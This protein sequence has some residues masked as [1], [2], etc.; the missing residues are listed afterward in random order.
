MTFEHIS[1]PVESRDVEPSTRG[2]GD[3]A[4]RAIAESRAGQRTST[5]RADH[6]LE[7]TLGARRSGRGAEEAT[8]VGQEVETS[9]LRRRH[10]PPQNFSVVRA[11]D[12]EEAGGLEARLAQLSGPDITPGQ[13]TI[14]GAAARS[15]YGHNAHRVPD[16][17]LQSLLERAPLFERYGV[18]TEA[19]FKKFLKP[20]IA[21]NFAP[22]IGRS[23][24]LVV[25]S[26]VGTFLGPH[27]PSPATGLPIGGAVMG[28]TMHTLAAQQGLEKYYSKPLHHGNLPESVQRRYDYFKEDPATVAVREEIKRQAVRV[29]V[30]LGS[31]IG[32]ESLDETRTVHNDVYADAA[33]FAFAAYIDRILAPVTA[34]EKIRGRYDHDT[35][36]APSPGEL[37]AHQPPETLEARLVNHRKGYIEAGADALAAMQQGVADLYRQYRGGKAV[38]V[39]VHAGFIIAVALALTQYLLEKDPKNAELPAGRISP[40]SALAIPG[41]LV[42]M[43]FF[44]TEAFAVLERT[45]EN[46]FS[47]A[48]RGPA[49]SGLIEEV[50]SDHD[51]AVEEHE[52]G[53]ETPEPGRARTDPPDQHGVSR[54]DPRAE[55]GRGSLDITEAPG[56]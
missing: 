18:R 42:I 3:E 24:Y 5:A 47:T 23:G 14:A 16:D 4:S 32:K 15:L 38:G 28:T 34:Y 10:A 43:E 7:E 27:V 36:A 22:L 9:S 50:G 2:D 41:A 19:E 49:P 12:A 35:L 44:A 25:L 45:L 17:V 54:P 31:M 52:D 33:T 46:A 21:E 56:P 55:A 8:T 40:A 29:L 39:A 6:P 30:T 26:V 20:T 13:R 11:R 1:N 48:R 51:E 37:I 53:H